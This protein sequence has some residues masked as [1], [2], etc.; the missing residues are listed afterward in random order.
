MKD[1]KNCL[2]S[3]KR[4]KNNWNSVPGCGSKTAQLM[5]VA[6][7]PIKMES[8]QSEPMVG[9]YGEVLRRVLDASSI[10]P[11][12]LW[13]DNL[14]KCVPLNDKGVLRAAYVEE[15]VKKCLPYL[16]TTIN[17]IK[18][19]LIVALGDASLKFLSGNRKI[20]IKRNHG[21]LYKLEKYNCYLMGTFHPKVI[22]AEYEYIKY[23]IQDF[24]KAK[25]FLETGEATITSTKYVFANDKQKL[26][27]VLDQLSKQVSFSFDI[28]T[29]GLNFLTDKVLCIGFSWAENSGAVIPFCNEK[30]EPFWDD[31]TLCDINH[32]LTNVFA[33]ESLKIA[34]N[35]SFD[36]LF[37]KRLGFKINNFAF[38]PMLAHHLL[39]E[40]AQGMRSLKQLALLYTDMGNYDSALDDY[41]VANKI[42]KN[43]GM[44][45]IPPD[46]LATYCAADVDCTFRLYNKFMKKLEDENLLNLFNKLTMPLCNVLI[47]TKYRGIKID[48][49]YMMSLRQK[50]EKQKQEL[51]VDL[52]A[53]NGG[54]FNIA[55]V[56]QL[57]EFLYKKLNLLPIVDKRTGQDKLTDSGELAT[58]IE[59]LQE[60]AR[61]NKAVNILIEY[62]KITK[63]LGTFINGLEYDLDARVHTSYNIAGTTSGRLSSSDPNCQ[64]IPR[65][66]TIKHL[67]C[68]KDGYS[69]VQCDL[70]AA[71]FRAWGHYSQDQKMIADIKSNFDIHRYTASKVFNLPEDKITKEQ[72]TAAKRVVFG[73]MYGQ[74]VEA[75]A[76][77]NGLGITQA[78]KVIDTFF[79]RYTRAK[80]WLEYVVVQAKQTKHLTNIFGRKRRF[81][82]FDS[83][84][85][86]VKALCERQAKNFLMQST[87]ADITNWAGVRL[88][89]ILSPYDSYLVLTVHDSLVYEVPDCHVDKVK[90]IIYA[91]ITKPIKG[92]TVP[93]GIELKVGKHWDD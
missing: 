67:F 51:E 21:Q 45:G 72:R 55:S 81:L 93:I 18:P 24:Q 40:N 50:F 61:Q 92:Y 70:S 41:K 13:K 87:V 12:I 74:G 65:D 48:L 76:V 3:E 16:E 79:G 4:I 2:L 82:G 75:T 36:V 78:R 62:R 25:Q 5:L 47:D 22:L 20:N 89:K 60:L 86:E 8:L 68:A 85:K 28:E 53:L 14:V 11:S 49:E 57:R 38:D 26:S 30:G 32:V 35:G 29:T 33:N 64:N 71:E 31:V 59:V 77:Q 7:S 69:L 90:D 34:Y 91:E 52:H 27:E 15:E 1:C 46:L 17:E 88:F 10:D 66:K 43:S 54:P 84:N 44:L 63:Y 56:P 58:D 39:D 42:P 83:P 9:L 19:K 73:L 37:L 6:E 80:A 23:M